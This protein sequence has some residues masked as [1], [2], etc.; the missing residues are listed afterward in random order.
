[1]AGTRL[2]VSRSGKTLAAMKGS[3]VVLPCLEY[4]EVKTVNMLRTNKGE[5]PLRARGGG[6]AHPSVT[7]LEIESCEK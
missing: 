2:G 5:I 6:V 3:T 7:V 4:K 1:M